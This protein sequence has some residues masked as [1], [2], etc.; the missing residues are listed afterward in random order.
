[1]AAYSG[2]AVWKE[3]G[4]LAKFADFPSGLEGALSLV[5]GMLLAFRANRAF[6][7]W[8]EGRILWGTLVNACRNLA[9]KANNVSASPDE[10]T[11][12]LQRLLVS[13]PYALRDHLR[14]GAKVAR[15]PDLSDER[16]D[17]QHVP[18]WIV[19]QMYGIFQTWKQE[20]RIEFSDF[21]MLDREAKILLEVCGGCERIRNTPIATSKIPTRTI[22]CLP[23]P[24][25][26]PMLFP[27][28]LASTK[29]HFITASC[30]HKLHQ[31]HVW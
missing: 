10:S 28:I 17:G 18:G 8:W 30:R 14:Q 31:V 2:L 11:A 9:V 13:F 23:L 1:M 25:L 7:R 4:P 21:W 5:I 22:S 24:T 15:L 6:D 27:M 19:N 29:K 3:H 12:R 26:T 20:Q 16:F